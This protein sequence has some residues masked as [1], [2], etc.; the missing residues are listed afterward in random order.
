LGSRLNEITLVT[1][2]DG[3]H[4]RAVAWAAEQLGCRAVIYMPKGTADA[5]VRN[6]RLH[7]ALAIVI[8]SSYDEAVDLA[9]LH[10]RER[11]WLLVQDTA[12]PGYREIPIRIMQGYLTLMREAIEQLEGQYPTHLFVQCGVGSLAAALAAFSVEC[13]DDGRPVFSVIEPKTAACFLRSM[14]AADS[15][16]VQ[17]EEKI[18]TIMAGLAC[19][20]PSTV[21]W[22]ILH[23]VAD[24]FIGCPDR[25]A[26]EGMRQ[27]AAPIAG[28]EPIVSGESGAVTAGLLSEIMRREKHEALVGTIGL[29]SSSKV[30]LISTEGDTD[31]EHYRKIVRTV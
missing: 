22:E 6:V 16:P 29:D 2:T 28:D 4:G 5:R 10:A 15:G 9:S 14:D 24:C 30:L 12:T 3:N 19:G 26:I 23:D 27:L 7:G 11:G 20:R 21:A 25:I 13:F 8:E 17:I 31:P 1:A 18:E